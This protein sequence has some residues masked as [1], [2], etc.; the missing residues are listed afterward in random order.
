[1]EKETNV[2]LFKDLEEIDV[3]K[4]L[5]F[6]ESK[7]LELKEHLKLK[8]NLADKGTYDTI[9]D[10]RKLVKR[11]RIDIPKARKEVTA[12]LNELIK[13]FIAEET[14]YVT[15]LTAIEEHLSA[16]SDKWKAEQERKKKIESERLQ[17][18][19]EDRLRAVAHMLTFDPSLDVYSIGN[20]SIT[21]DGIKQKSDDEWQVFCDEAGVIYDEKVAV[22]KAA[23]EQAEKDKKELEELRAE[24]ARI[25]AQKKNI[26]PVN[27]EAIPVK[28]D[29]SKIVSQNTDS[30]AEKPTDKDKVAILISDFKNINIPVLDDKDANDV[31]QK[32]SPT[33]SSTIT[34]L[35]SIHDRL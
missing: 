2:I 6:S 23:K 13:R 18:L 3:S 27:T 10:A 1:M 11:I 25:N 30:G 26:E 8:I 14:K 33:L 12:P 20:L 16:E 28:F 31:L 5:S 9:E 34:W 21:I 35:Q 29:G 4:A 22:E 17:R 24:R 19:F 15:E 7:L 32:L